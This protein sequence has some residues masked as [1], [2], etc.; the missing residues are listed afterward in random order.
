MDIPFEW[1]L[2]GILAFII[3]REL[4]CWY[5]KTSDILKEERKQTRILEEILYTMNPRATYFDEKEEEE[6]KYIL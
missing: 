3:L 5:W 6:G 4:M 2:I 1:I